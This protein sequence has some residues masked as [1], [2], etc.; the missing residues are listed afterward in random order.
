MRLLLVES[1]VLALGG[2]ALGLALALG[3]IELVR[4]LGLDRSSDGFA[5]TLDAPCL[6]FTLGTAIVAALVSGLPPVIALLRDD[7][8]ARYAR[9]G[10]RAAA[11]AAHTRCATRSW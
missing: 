11:A 4:A 9:P 5:V 7:L 10:A 8:H 1:L 6:A 3:G 2:G